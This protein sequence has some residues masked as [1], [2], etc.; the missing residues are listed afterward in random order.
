MAASVADAAVCDEIKAVAELYANAKK[1]MIVY[2]Q[3]VLSVEAALWL[4]RSRCCPAISERRETAS[5]QSDRRTTLR[6]W[7]IW[8]SAPALRLWK[9]SRD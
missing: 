4:L 9:A 6:V 1:A 7:R 2:Q 3:N 5:W 8:V